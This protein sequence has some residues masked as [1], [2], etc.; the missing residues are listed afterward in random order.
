MAA[1]EVM[2]EAL[3]AA[4][5]RLRSA[6]AAVTSVAGSVRTAG[7]VATGDPAVA[8]G[9]DALAS[10]LGQTVPALAGGHDGLSRAVA[11]SAARYRA[12]DSRIGILAAAEQVPVGM[13][14]AAGIEPA[15]PA[16]RWG[17][18]V[19]PAPPGVQT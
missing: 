19:I 4:S 14:G 1:V 5:D 8:A 13:V 16:E 10:R 6:G 15:V 11:A 2:A 18:A 9:L 17:Q 7:T 12:T 3:E